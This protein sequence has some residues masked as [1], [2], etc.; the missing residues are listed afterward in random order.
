MLDTLGI[1]V[2]D[3]IFNVH[4]QMVEPVAIGTPN[5]SP[6]FGVL[7]NTSDFVLN[8]TLPYSGSPNIAEEAP[9]V[10]PFTVG[11]TPTVVAGDTLAVAQW[12]WRPDSNLYLGVMGGLLEIANDE[13][14]F[15]GGAN[16]LKL[17]IAVHVAGWKSMMSKPS[18]SRSKK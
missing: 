17:S 15:D 14:D 5:F 13:L 12:N 6:G 18:K 11:Y 9:E 10:I 1:G 16:Q 7:G 3:S 4:N 2:Q 8:D